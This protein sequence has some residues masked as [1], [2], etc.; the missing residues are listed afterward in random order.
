MSIVD[1]SSLR[2]QARHI[3]MGVGVTVAVS[4][5]VVTALGKA[6]G[7]AHLSEELHDARPG[8]LI[9]CL[10]GQ[11]AVFAGYAGALRYAV[12]WD[13]GPRMDQATSWRIVLASFAATQL[14]AFGGAA[15]LA[16]LYW[17]F[18]RLSLTRHEAAVR[19]IGLSTAVYLVFGAIAWLAAGWSALIGTAPLGVTVPWLVIF[20][21]IL[22]VARWFTSDVR[23]AQW[24][25]SGN[26]PGRAFRTAVGTGVESATWVRT[27]MVTPSARRLLLWALLYWIGDI[28]CLW[29]A[30]HAFG[31]RPALAALV[32]AYATGYLV[33]ALPIPFIA[34]GGVDAAT[35]LMLH[36]VGV[37]LDAALAA[38]V[39]HRLFAFWLP[40]I[41]G[42][43]FAL[44]LPRWM[45]R[46]VD[47][48]IS[49]VKRSG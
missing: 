10:L 42:S 18:R 44:T 22:L 16:I 9:V 46:V 15:G 13:A 40:V 36:V 26:A 47:Q 41:P 1:D 19:V 29:A 3:V 4:V 17:S 43:V 31:A 35:T 30:T 6:A 45:P 48:S 34:S 20:P 12:A 8:W 21:S 38:V 25:D 23:S 11:V 28:A 32:V 5:L 49:A 33:Q 14:I 2:P 39:T 27:V 37:P 24:I 7:F